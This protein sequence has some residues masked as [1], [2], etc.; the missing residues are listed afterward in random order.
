[1]H[2]TYFSV[3]SVPQIASPEARNIFN[4]KMHW[5]NILVYLKSPRRR[6]EKKIIAK[7][8]ENCTGPKLHV[9]K[10]RGRLTPARGK[11]STALHRPKTPCHQ[12]SRPSNPGGSPRRKEG[13]GG[14]EGRRRLRKKQNLNQGVRKNVFDMCLSLFL[15]FEKIIEEMYRCWKN[16]K[17]FL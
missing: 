9:S 16:K 1:M 2:W 5:T 15:F 7:C 14:K 3:P 12:V 11:Y 6:R 17:M 13:G 8:I 10:F 4:R